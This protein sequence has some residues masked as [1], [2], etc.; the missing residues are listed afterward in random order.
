[1]RLE[2]L[3]Y[4]CNLNILLQGNIPKLFFKL[5]YLIYLNLCPFIPELKLWVFLGDHL[6]IDTTYLLPLVR[7]G[8][9][10]DLLRAIAE[11]RTKERISFTDLKVSLI[12][13][14]EMQAKASRLDIPPSDV[15]KAIEV[16]LKTFR[17][18]PFYTEKII[19]LAHKLKELIEDYMDRIILAT[20]IAAGESLITEDS[21]ILSIKDGIRQKYNIQIKTYKDLA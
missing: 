7:I 17:V 14:F 19:T 2:K 1:M 9:E 21:R 15:I 3:S 4:N 11:N 18:I 5:L 13:L 6:I 10:T 12:S 8:V 20:A 16:I